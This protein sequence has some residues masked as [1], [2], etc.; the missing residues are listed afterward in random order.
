MKGELVLSS[1]D[2]R[3]L[4]RHV[5]QHGVRVA[6]RRDLI[7]AISVVPRD[8]WR[9]VKGALTTPTEVKATDFE[10]RREMVEGVENDRCHSCVRDF[11]VMPILM[12]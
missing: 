6:Q 2:T 9:G 5:F 7:D 1:R 10:A 3:W 8:S 12:D 4:A 11:I